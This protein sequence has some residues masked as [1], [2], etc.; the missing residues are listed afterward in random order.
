MDFEIERYQLL[1]IMYVG[2]M[3]ELFALTL[4]MQKKLIRFVFTNEMS[5]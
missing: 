2:K 1:S 3:T 5:V 4:E